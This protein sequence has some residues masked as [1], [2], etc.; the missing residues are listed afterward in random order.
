MRFCGRFAG[1]LLVA[2][3]LV[4]NASA[5]VSGMMRAQASLWG[6][7][8]EP[9][10]A[11][12]RA[13]FSPNCLNADRRKWRSI[14]APSS[15]MTPPVGE[16]RH[17]VWSIL[18]ADFMI[19]RK[20]RMSRGEQPKSVFFDSA[21]LIRSSISSKMVLKVTKPPQRDRTTQKRLPVLKSKKGRCRQSEGCH[22]RHCQPHRRIRAWRERGTRIPIRH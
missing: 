15:T 4:S 12:V 6:I 1:F 9:G 19:P 20:I 10:S 7:R 21:S 17:S 22:R 3:G 18:S 11:M 13:Q 16:S 2:A 14:I 5:S 8:V